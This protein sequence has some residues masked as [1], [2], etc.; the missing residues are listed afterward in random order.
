MAQISSS[1]A[2][3]DALA[4]R[5]DTIVGRDIVPEE[6]GEGSRALV[7][8][9]EVR[10]RSIRGRRRRQ[11]I[12]TGIIIGCVLAAV[13]WGAFVDRPRYAAETR[14]S[15]RGSS[16]EQ[17]TS[18]AATSLLSSGSGGSA[19]IGFVDGFAV[20]D[21]LKSRD[22]MIQ[23][24]KVMPLATLL[25]VDPK[26]GSSALYDAYSRAVKVKFF[27][28]EQENSIEV[29]AFSPDDSRRIA[30]ALLVLAQQF[31]GKMDTQGVQ[32]A[33]NV[34]MRQL[35]A[36]Q[37]QSS[38]AANSMAAWSAEHR[39]VDPNA[40][41]TMVLNNIAQLEQELNTA[42]INYEKVQ[43]FGNPDHPMLKPAQLQVQALQGQLAQAR[44]RLAGGQNS[45][46][47]RLR[48]F[49]QLKNA[50]TF[51]DSNLSA[52]RDAYQQS[53]REATRLRRYLSVISEPVASDVPSSPNLWL[54]AVQGLL[55][56]IVISFLASLGMGLTRRS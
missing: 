54:L 55:A 17:A 36:A 20:N 18:G 22:A 53:Y 15:V 49:S 8:A 6:T 26:A 16:A 30:S 5:G 27:M 39:D 48:T 34:D 37:I 19:G 12:Y 52:A 46:A 32:D 2:R 25:G 43:A 31:V 4:D 7:L 23:L 44:A 29:D 24:N 21:F 40:E 9:R 11:W 41:A 3:R 51:A 35:Q 28:V 13:G 45:E 42:K 14:F 10:E 38:S 56:G 50:Q 1:E 33:L 47:S